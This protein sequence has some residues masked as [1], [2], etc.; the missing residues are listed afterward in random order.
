MKTMMWGL[1]LSL[2]LTVSAFA[3]T[4]LDMN[5]DAISAYKK[6]DK[7]LNLVYK[8]LVGKI[9]EQEKTNLKT[10]QRKWIKMKES[11]CTKEAAEYEGGSMYPMIYHDCLASKTK[12]RIIELKKMLIGR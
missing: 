8:Q 12:K 10:A 11:S 6:A 2:G 3:Q 5:V 4:Q 1:F 7:E 9:S